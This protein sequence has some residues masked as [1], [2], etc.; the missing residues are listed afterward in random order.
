MN[1]F[2]STTEAVRK[3]LIEKDD[4]LARSESAKL[5]ERRLKEYNITSITDLNESELQDFLNSLKS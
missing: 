5:Y 4:E 1:K 2:T 3:A